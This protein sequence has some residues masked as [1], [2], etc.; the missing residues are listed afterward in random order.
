MAG[1]VIDGSLG[2]ERLARGLGGPLGADARGARARKRV[3]SSGRR[4][5]R[6]TSKP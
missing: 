1:A 2:K 4:P 3:L 5:S 6:V